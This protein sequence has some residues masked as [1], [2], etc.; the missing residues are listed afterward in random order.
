MPRKMRP[1][2]VE[3]GTDRGY[4]WHQHHDWPACDPCRIAHSAAS[5]ARRKVLVTCRDCARLMPRGSRGRCASCYMR[6][7]VFV[8]GK[9]WRDNELKRAKERRAAAREARQKARD[10]PP[11]AP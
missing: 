2:D 10:E 5:A 1:E 7:M 4:A 9:N 6:Y 11:S 3:H 8:K